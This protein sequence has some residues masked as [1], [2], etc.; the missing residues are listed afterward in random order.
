[1]SKTQTQAEATPQDLEE[2]KRAIAY[3][4]WE[5]EGQ[6]HGQ[7]ELHWERAC[8]VVMSLD[9]EQTANPGWLKRSVSV[10]APA[11]PER[12]EPVATVE[13]MTRR[14]PSRNAA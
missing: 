8:L 1:M 13:T 9:A 2:R 11:A 3:Q 7:A 12:V 14:M 6:P 5:E 10:A 4:I